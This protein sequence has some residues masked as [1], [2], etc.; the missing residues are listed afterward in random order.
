MNYGLCSRETN[1]QATSVKVTLM[2]QHNLGEWK[3]LDSVMDFQ[4][5]PQ[6]IQL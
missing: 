4:G 2:R 6:I 5:H 3:H 1:L